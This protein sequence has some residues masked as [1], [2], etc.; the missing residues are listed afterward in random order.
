MLNTK[1]S[2]K[3][4]DDVTDIFGIAPNLRSSPQE[5]R[6]NPA[7]DGAKELFFDS[8]ALFCI[9]KGQESYRP[10]ASRVKVMTTMMNLY[11]VYYHLIKRAWTMKPM[12]SSI[13]SS[14]TASPA[15]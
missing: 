12:S 7:K 10:Y 11:E 2:A 5:F 13:V 1:V 14:S 3:R 6:M 15:T 8:Y 9:V 4:S